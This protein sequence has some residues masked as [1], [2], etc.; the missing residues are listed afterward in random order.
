[1]SKEQDIHFPSVSRFSFSPASAAALY[2]VIVI[3]GG[4]G[5]SAAAIS[6]AQQGAK[7]LLVEAGRS[8]RHKM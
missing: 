2:D 3:G 6:I 7:V 8:P 1:M 5:G 4:V